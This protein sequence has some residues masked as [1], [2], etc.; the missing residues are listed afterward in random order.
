[1]L[2][3]MALITTAMTS[4]LLRLLGYPSGDAVRAEVRT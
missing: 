2:M 3:L 4:P 1:M